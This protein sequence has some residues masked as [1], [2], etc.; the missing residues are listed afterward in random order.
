MFAAIRN[1]IISICT[2]ITTLFGSANKGAQAIDVMADVA[3]EEAQHF[4]DIKRAERAKLIEA[5]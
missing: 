4:R 5:E 2:A 3:L 1:A